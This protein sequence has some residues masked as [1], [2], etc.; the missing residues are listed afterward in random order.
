MKK[1]GFNAIKQLCYNICEKVEDLSEKELVKFEKKY[2][3]SSMF[4][5][6]FDTCANNIENLRRLD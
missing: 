1:I 4:Y 6:A 3:D 5:S 2:N